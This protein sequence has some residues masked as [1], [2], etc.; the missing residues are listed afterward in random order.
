MAMSGDLCCTQN[1]GQCIVV[2]MDGRVMLSRQR[3]YHALRLDH[4][5]L[6]LW[7]GPGR[8]QD[9]LRTGANTV[10]IPRNAVLIGQQRWTPLRGGY[11]EPS[12]WR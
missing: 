9:S 4:A 6:G 5:P 3:S 8:R 11:V 1:A 10:F 12:Q 2:G 7:P